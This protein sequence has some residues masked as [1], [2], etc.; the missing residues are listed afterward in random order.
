VTFRSETPKTPEHRLEAVLARISGLSLGTEPDVA[1]VATRVAALPQPLRL[2]VVER[3]LF[4][5]D[6]A[7]PS[8]R[9]GELARATESALRAALPGAFH[10]GSVA[11]EGELVLDAI[12]AP[13]DPILLGVHRH[14]KDRSPHPGGRYVYELPAE[15]PSR[16]YRKTEESILSF[17]LPLLPGDTAVELGA[18]P[19]GGTLALLRRGLN[20]IAVD[21]AEM[22][23][24]AGMTHLRLPM[25]QVERSISPRRSSGSS[26]T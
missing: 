10:E 15:A 25:Q 22:E 5:A 17:E 20:V 4:R 14:S 12:V 16:A 1:H 19:G 18:A 9:E 26:W 24:R 8:H 7:P 2:H 3:D 13:G 23:P 6:E 21:P 11:L